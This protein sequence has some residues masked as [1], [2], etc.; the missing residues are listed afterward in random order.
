MAYPNGL[1]A[2]STSNP[3]LQGQVRIETTPQQSV[4][5]PVV[6]PY[7]QPVVQQSYYQPVA[8]PQPSYLA[9]QIANNL[10]QP[11]TN[12]GDWMAANER[13][14]QLQQEQRALNANLAPAL[15]N[16]FYDA[17]RAEANRRAKQVDPNSMSAQIYN[18]IANN[19][20]QMMVPGASFQLPT[21]DQQQAYLGLLQQQGANISPA[22][23][24]MAFDNDYLFNA[25]GRNGLYSSG[26]LGNWMANPIG[27]KSMGI[28]GR[29]PFKTY[30]NIDSPESLAY[31]GDGSQ[32]LQELQNQMLRDFRW[33][34]DAYNSYMKSINNKNPLGGFRGDIGGNEHLLINNLD[35]L[36]K[37]ANTPQNM[38]WTQYPLGN[39]A[40]DKYIK[41]WTP[42][43]VTGNYGYGKYVKDIFA[44]PN[45]NL[46][47]V[48]LATTLSQNMAP[49]YFPGD[50]P[51]QFKDA[52]PFFSSND[53]SVLFPRGIS[54]K[55][56]NGNSI[57]PARNTGYGRN[58]GVSGMPDA[59]WIDTP[60]DNWRWDKG[61][62]MWTQDGLPEPVD[63]VNS[64]WINDLNFKG[65]S[66][67]EKNQQLGGMGVLTPMMG[68]AT[69]PQIYSRPKPQAVP[70]VKNVA[71]SSGGFGGTLSPGWLDADTTYG[72]LFQPNYKERSYRPADKLDNSG[73][74]QGML[75]ALLLG[76]R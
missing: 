30:Q 46:Q 41:D 49:A 40:Y 42:A 64:Q 47:F 22:L 31:G 20:S 32:M 5:Q 57:G 18:A 43:H 37:K 51:T 59:D 33:N 17:T 15:N 11:I 65:Q 73:V 19:G 2:S 76:R 70:K 8:Q 55:D 28:E 45:G 27:Y 50:P 26:S 54:A 72:P 52:E 67:A 60:G 62:G 44:G 29:T 10:N 21:G 61:E 53:P 68:Y 9:Q 4:Y 3:V 25:V 75:D 1:P 16:A 38:D 69:A 6:Q 35:E 14:W 39:H 56:P 74:L 58:G 36:K 12:T 7:Y 71:N 63:P 24:Q 48:P 34:Q 66:E 23:Q 13:N